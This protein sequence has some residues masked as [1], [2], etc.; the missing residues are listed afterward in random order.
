L[1][2]AKRA[3]KTAPERGLH[4]SIHE[5]LTAEL[6]GPLLEGLKEVCRRK[7]RDAIS[8]LGEFLLGYPL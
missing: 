1:E 7:P 6:R 8:F 5:L 3:P 2:G 4:L